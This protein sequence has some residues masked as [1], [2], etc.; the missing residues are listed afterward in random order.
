MVTHRST[1]FATVGAM[2]QSTGTPT[3]Q[4]RTEDVVREI[5]TLLLAFAP[6]D[7]ALSEHAEGQLTV[8]LI[9]LLVGLS[10]VSVSI[11][12]ESRRRKR[13]A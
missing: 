13:V 2:S 7:V 9:F 12:A 8:L 4:E 6:L 11:A 5:G 10:F 1:L 3:P